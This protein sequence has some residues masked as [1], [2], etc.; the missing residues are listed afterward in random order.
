[1]KSSDAELVLRVLVGLRRQVTPEVHPRPFQPVHD[2]L[3]QEAMMVIKLEIAS[4][5]RRSETKRKN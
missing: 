3:V 2:A 5:S 4:N 1:V